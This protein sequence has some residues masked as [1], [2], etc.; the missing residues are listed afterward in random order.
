MVTTLCPSLGNCRVSASLGCGGT[1]P[2]TALWTQGR[3]MSNGERSL[4][5]SFC[6][7]LATVTSLARQWRRSRRRISPQFHHSKIQTPFAAAHGQPYGHKSRQ[8]LIQQGDTSVSK[9]HQG[10]TWPTRQQLAATPGPGEQDQTH[11]ISLSQ[12]QAHC[13]GQG[14][15]SHHLCTLELL[16]CA[17]C[18]PLA[19]FFWQ[20]GHSTDLLHFGISHAL[21][22]PPGPGWPQQ[23]PKPHHCPD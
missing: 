21:S 4:H 16:S 23:R 15:T 6:L 19:H 18:H 22:H 3:Y 1:H 7:P 12:S 20:P 10:V 13:P 17:L 11:F 8:M 2:V 5:R 9:G 14:I